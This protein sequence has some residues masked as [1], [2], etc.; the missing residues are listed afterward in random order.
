MLRFSDLGPTQNQASNNV[1]RL[2]WAQAS[3][4]IDGIFILFGTD[5]GPK[6]EVGLL[7]LEEKKKKN[8]DRVYCS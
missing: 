2:K 1:N 4:N 5:V 7:V 3:K 8:G 6:L